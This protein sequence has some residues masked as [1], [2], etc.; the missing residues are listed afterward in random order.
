MALKHSLIKS[1]QMLG[2]HL[3]IADATSSF[4]SSQIMAIQVSLL[5]HLVFGRDVPEL[6]SDDGSQMSP[7]VA[8][9]Q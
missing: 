8:A 9:T 2:Y 7:T 3:Y 6:E 1:C 5:F 4:N